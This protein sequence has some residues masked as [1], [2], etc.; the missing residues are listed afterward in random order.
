MEKTDLIAGRKY[1]IDCHPQ[2]PHHGKV[3]KFMA[4]KK[5]LIETIYVHET[6]SLKGLPQLIYITHT[7]LKQIK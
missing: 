7:A 5:D 4:V 1:R 3:V 2:N 6:G